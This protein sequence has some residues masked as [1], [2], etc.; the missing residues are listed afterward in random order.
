MK[1][2][3]ISWVPKRFG[4]PEIF[5]VL[6]RGASIALLI[7]IAGNGIGY[8]GQ[9]LLARWLGANGYGIFSYLIT[10][11][12]VFTIVALIG[13]DL[14]IVRFIPEYIARQDWQRL[15]GMLHWSRRLG[16]GAG[17][18]LAAASAFI[19]F[20]LRPVSS[21][22]ITL[23]LGSLLI[24]LG[25]LAEVQTEI[26]RS[27]KRIGWA[28]GPTV[29]IQPLLLLGL[30]YT[31]LRI[32][33]GLKDYFSILA[34]VGSM[35][36]VVMLQALKIQQI[37]SETIQNVS[38]IY[39]GHAWLKVFFPLLFNSIFIV[40]LLRVDTLV[41]GYFKGAAEVGIYSAAVKTSAIVGLTLFAINSIVAPLIASYYARRDMAGLQNVVSL[42][43]LGSFSAAVIIGL[44]VIL[45]N[46]TILGAFGAEFI[47][48][49]LPLFILLFGQFVNVGSG[50]IGL[51]MQLTGFERQSMWVLCCCSLM[52]GI[53]CVVVVPLFGIVGAAI[54][55]V[56]GL[57]LWNVWIYRLVVKNLGIHASIFFAIKNAV[58]IRD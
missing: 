26:L 10:W 12:Q 16:L 43:T 20:F 30:V 32:L 29:L 39:E 18:L 46:G 9:I 22:A 58:W 23:L 42:A 50:S 57:L 56:A 5:G 25:V 52:T 53:A 24:P 14:G 35:C 8:I 40:I 54:V 3:I 4:P 41:V 51:L 55:S 6:F 34:L 44:G 17:I 48:G 21:S 45:F 36:L 1:D 31:L 37:F 15:S 33:G 19:L 11:A 13:M 2:R 47:R 38:A 27:T 7:Q 49:R 28:Y